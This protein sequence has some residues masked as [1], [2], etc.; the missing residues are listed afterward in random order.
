MRNPIKNMVRNSSLPLYRMAKAFLTTLLLAGGVLLSGMTHSAETYQYDD[1]G[2]LTRVIYDNGTNITYTYDNM[3]NITNKVMS[4][5]PIL[6]FTLDVTKAGT[7][8]GRVSSDIVG[9]DCGLDCNEVYEEN[10][11]V[12]LTATPDAGALFSGWS[13]GGCSGTATCT[14]PMSANTTVT[15][16]FD[17]IPVPYTVTLNP[18]G[19]GAGTV[20]S[21]PVGIDCGIDCTEVYNSG[22]S[23]TL[24]A[25]AAAGS[26]FTG[27]SGGGC[28]G[29]A[30]C[31]FTVSAD[32]TI[33]AD[34]ARLFTLTTV[35][36]GSGTVSSAAPGIDCGVDCTEIYVEGTSV[37]LSAV[38]TAG[39][40]FT[41]WSGGGCSGTGACTVS[42]SADTTV[43]ATFTPLYSLNVTKTGT[44]SGTI[45]SA[46]AGISCGADCVDVLPDGSVI[47]LTAT[48]DAGFAFTGW[49][50]GGCSGIGECVIT[51]NGDT[52]V[53]ASFA[54]TFTLTTILAGSGSGTISSSPAGINC[55]S[56]CNEVYGEGMVI[57]LTPNAGVNS[58]FTGW[59]G[60][61]C[62]GTGPCDVTLTADTTVTATFGIGYQ[63]NVS[64]TGSGTGTVTSA[65]FGIDCGADCTEGYVDGSVVTLTAVASPGSIFTGWS[66]GGCSGTGNCIV[67]MT[68]ANSVSANFASVYTVDVTTS[69]TGG[70]TVQSSPVGIDC[71]VDCTEIVSDETTLQLSATAAAGSAFTG[72]SGGVCSGT[73]SCNFTPSVDV[74]IDAAFNTDTDG[75]GVADINDSAPNDATIAS[76]SDL[77]G[78]GAIV[79]DVSGNTGAT[80]ARVNIL[81]DSDT[82]LVQTN[83]PG[84]AQF[85]YGVVTYEVNVAAAGD[86][87]TVVL[88][89]PES[90]PSVA[91]Y[92]QV[93]ASGFSQFGSITVNG[94]QL[95]V[96]LIDGGPGDADG[97]A[98]GVIVHAAG[99]GTVIVAPD[100]QVFSDGGY[101]FI[102]TAAYGSYLDPD[103]AVLRKFRDDY[104]KTNALGSW[105][106]EFYYE[107]SP[108]IANYIA[109]H[110]ALRA[111]VRWMLTP[112]VY[113]VKYPVITL[114]LMLMLARKFVKRYQRRRRAVD[115]IDVSA[116]A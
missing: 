78:I 40:I 45:N 19:L 41:G 88:D 91:Q 53:S 31:T 111:I 70:G 82:L 24:D 21:N 39:N 7:S 109:Q 27:W 96:T 87:I 37:E 6:F 54:P 9:I 11:S 5:T 18:T 1:A 51:L 89:Y 57:T 92:Y 114:L 68:A 60:G 52:A 75:D 35:A 113:G 64:K 77:A 94:T 83:K 44:G 73:G 22:T 10:T 101:C 43:S 106:V 20:T 100:V 108:P 71:G 110:E 66:G 93:D 69:G 42:M 95:T 61:G 84:N 76:L 63:L 102:A 112:I 58:S 55:G 62:T 23:L 74:T 99:I 33:T 12:T 14:V 97:V 116:G 46:P 28:S 3:G 81:A 98:N 32:T 38:A 15:A 85:R 29:T 47:T 36:T 79:I 59:S 50:G 49:S 56:D 17:V 90:I 25:V 65:P 86:Q 80:L 16:T 104:L 30:S 2:R 105:F 26:I 4:T 107:H 34:F 67:T 103:V 8:T 13:G 72:W 48:A 115:L